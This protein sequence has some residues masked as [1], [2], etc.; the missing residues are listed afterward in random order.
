MDA[1]VIIAGA[2]PV[3]LMLAAE[4]RLHGVAVLVLDPLDRPSPFSRAFGLHARSTGT[5]ALRGLVEPLRAAGEAE[6]PRMFGGLRPPVGPGGGIPLVHFAGIRTVRL[7]H[8]GTAHPGMLSVPQGGVEAVLAERATALGAEIRRGTAVTG[9]TQDSDTVTVETDNSGPLQAR[10]L[11]GC[12]GGR[13]TVRKLTGTGFPGSDPTITGRLVEAAVPALLEHPGGGWHRTA[14]GVVQVL[15]GR[16]LTVEFDRPTHDRNEPMG[17]QEMLD[18]IHR[19]IGRQVEF[20]AE[21]TWL[22]RFTDNTRLAEDYRIGRVLLAGDAAHVHSPFGGQG[23]NLGL[24]DAANLG[25]KLAAEVAGWAPPGLLDSYQLER[26]PVAARV[27]HNTR[28]QVALMNPD[29]VTTPLREV[30]AE[31]ME[32][33]EANRYLGELLSAV[34]VRYDLGDGHPL[35]GGFLPSGLADR[36][37]L[38]QDGC[39]VLLLLDAEAA[40]PLAK[41]ASDWTDRV[42]QHGPDAGAEPQAR[43]DPPAAALTKW[44][45]AAAG[46]RGRPGRLRE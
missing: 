9:F 36:E 37:P 17:P 33:P 27:L 5:M 7:D 39:G 29:P 13:S 11:V 10:W 8:L 41:A 18:S 3:G 43:T 24:Q 14:G 32:L 22:T 12:D 35:T 4:L 38:F 16:I 25:W 23:L 21:P 15:P 40:G 31:L 34:G 45:G 2:G 19:V 44:F 26:R 6:G 20:A 1:D 28:A 46:G 30:F 42:R